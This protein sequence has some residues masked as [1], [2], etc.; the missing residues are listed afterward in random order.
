MFLETLRQ[1]KARAE[2]PHGQFWYTP[3]ELVAA[4][5]G[6]SPAHLAN[7]LRREGLTVE[8]DGRKRKYPRPTVEALQ[9]VYCRGIGLSTS[10]GY[11]TAICTFSRWL[12]V[13]VGR[14]G[15]PG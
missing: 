5:G 2:L 3:A 12:A 14:P 8:E 1:D 9:D 10:N 13:R 15:G 11:A 4:L 6:R 7:V